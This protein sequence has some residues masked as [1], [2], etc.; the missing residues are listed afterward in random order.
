MYSKD[1]TET[2]GGGVAIYTRNDKESS[3]IS[4]KILKSTL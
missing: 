4:D 2:I 3:P 1:R